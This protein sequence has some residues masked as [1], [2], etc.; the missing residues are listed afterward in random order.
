MISGRSVL[1]EDEGEP[2]SLDRGVDG[3]SHGRGRHGFALSLSLSF[4]GAAAFEMGKSSLFVN[5][6]FLFLGWGWLVI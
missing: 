3:M 6:G 4:S 2:M 1:A 5:D